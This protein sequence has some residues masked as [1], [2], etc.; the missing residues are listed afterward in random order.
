MSKN[1]S[2]GRP[3]GNIFESVQIPSIPRNT[4][5]LSHQHYSS[6]NMAR[7][8][9]VFWMDTTPGDR[10][11]LSI[12]QLVRFA[13]MTFPVFSQFFIKY[14]AFAVPIR[15]LM[16][17]DDY[18]KF[19]TGGEDGKQI[20]PWP[21]YSLKSI[22]AAT[23][24]TNP[25]DEEDGT[26][27]SSL[28]DYLG[29][30]VANADGPYIYDE[31]PET[32][33]SVLPFRAY[34]FIYNEWFRD[35]KL[36][37]EVEWERTSTV[38]YGEL[39]EL[40]KLRRV[41][42]KKDYFTSA[43]TEPQ[44]GEDVFLPIGGDAPVY[45]RQATTLIMQKYTNNGSGY[46]PAAGVLNVNDL[47]VVRS[48]Q[49]SS[50][51]LNLASK[52]YWDQAVGTD[53]YDVPLYADLT[54]AVSASI[55]ELRAS[56]AIQRW[57]ELNARAG[58]RLPEWM[59]AHFHVRSSDARLQRP[60]YLGGMSVRVSIG[61]VLQT[62][63]NTEDSALG[64]FAGHGAAYAD[65]FLFNRFIEEQSIVMVLA[66]V[67]P[68]PMYTTGMDR[69]WFK[70]DK[71]DFVDPMFGNLGEQEV[72]N[73]ELYLGPNSLPETAKRRF[74]FQSRYAEYKYKPSRVSGQM[75]TTLKA[76]HVGREFNQRPELTSGFVTAYPSDR[77]FNVID[78]KEDKLFF[79]F[80]FNIRYT[81]SLPYYGTPSII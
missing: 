37:A 24:R 16:P 66:Y 35:Q 46:N 62:S 52:A 69:F 33:I 31:F 12:E 21:M 63:S 28:P 42:W 56:L 78:E 14:R 49:D 29:I 26:Y 36:Q 10:I 40:T 43:F 47:G 79:N 34:Q 38:S 13:P 4:F 73:G 80:N 75:R 74:G 65:G 48:S 55:N 2:R 22:I 44:L 51:S 72:W 23:D 27:I 3:S 50:S 71:F 15:L 11:A 39:S 59:L 67:V 64:D 53:V 20:A 45:G 41:N 9:P 19:V 58:V 77:I 30:E 76:W 17:Q 25:L 57:K 60:E 81:T 54:N 6:G 68:K 8:I 70:D 18:E 32:P 1:P 5:D 61:E 7:L